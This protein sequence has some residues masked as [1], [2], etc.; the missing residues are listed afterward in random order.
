MF[1]AV[2]IK[3]V[4]IEIGLLVRALRKQR[5]LSQ[6]QLAEVLDVS[7]A[8][9]QNMETGKNFTIDTLLKVCKEMDQL[10]E[11]KVKVEHVRM[12]IINTQSLY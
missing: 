10:T 7:R 6:L 1:D 2:E 3:D 8:T 4:K 9:I 5:R 12:Q 11:L